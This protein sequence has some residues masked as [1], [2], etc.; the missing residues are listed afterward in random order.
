MKYEGKLLGVDVYSDPE[1]PYGKIYFIEGKI[2]LPPGLIFSK[3]VKY[4]IKNLIKVTNSTI[5]GAKHGKVR[6]RRKTTD[7]C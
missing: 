7:S 5:K 1:C 6:G 2:I 4:K 3:S